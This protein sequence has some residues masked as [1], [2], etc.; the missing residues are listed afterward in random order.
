MFSRGR[1]G[2]G[3]GGN[4]SIKKVELEVVSGDMLV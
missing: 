1:M 4:A 3:G 2:A